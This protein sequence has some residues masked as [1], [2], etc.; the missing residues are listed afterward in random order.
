MNI[1]GIQDELLRLEYPK[2]LPGHDPDI[3]HYFYL[4]STNRDADAI[5]VY[6]A[7]LIPRYPNDEF[8]TWLLRA[9]RNRDPAFSGLLAKGRQMLALRL[10]ERTKAIIAYIAGKTESL[11]EKDVYSTIKTAEGI[12][13]IL[14]R[15]RY[16]AMT[17]MDRYQRYAET[18]NLREDAIVKANELVQAYLTDSLSVVQ[19]ERQR[20]SEAERFAREQERQRLVRADYDNYLSQKEKAAAKRE[21]Q[22]HERRIDPRPPAAPKAHPIDLSSIIFSQRD[23]ARIEIPPMRRIEDQVLAYCI[24]YWNMINDNSFERI[25]FLYS[26]KYRKKNYDIYMTIRRGRT[27]KHRDDE[28]LSSILSLLITGYYYSIRG[29]R[30]L[31]R[32]WNAVKAT[33]EK[34][35]VQTRPG[36]RPVKTAPA[37]KAASTQAVPVKTAPVQPKPAVPVKTAPAEAA[38]PAKAVPPAKAAPMQPVQPVPAKTAPVQPKPAH[39]T[40]KPA[41]QK[42]K[43]PE[44]QTVRQ[45][46]VKGSVQDRLKELSGRSYDVYQ[47]R[48]FT[49][50]RG[51]IR[52]VLGKKKGLFAN[53]SE[54]AENLVYNFLS[55]HYSDPFMNWE[56]AAERKRLFDMGFDLPS[57]T[58][59][60]DECYKTL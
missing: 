21:Q 55:A 10:L 29:D 13:Q 24:K 5:V 46:A 49:K 23:L 40:H 35:A 44:I 33:V 41:P 59:V 36:S 57:I 60:I 39:P 22:Q 12:L 25:L 32:S 8:R 19:E 37:A 14:P 28:I 1:I 42:E 52:K 27:A 31:L 43:V 6:R 38:V 50:V 53:L 15:D 18:L 56:D 2:L 16:E 48:F 54:E 9:Y 7:R 3:E 26:R 11:N 4:R 17:V 58:P 47:D 30:Y 45:P 51:A 20:R 34:Q